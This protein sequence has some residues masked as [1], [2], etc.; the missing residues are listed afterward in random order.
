MTMKTIS[1]GDRGPAV[2]DIQRRLLFLG[3][4][5]GS[6]GVDGD[7]QI[8]TQE[9]IAHFQE[10]SDLPVTGI[11]DDRTWSTLVDSSFAFGDRLL[12]LRAPYFH[13]N[14]VAQLQEILNTLGFYCGSVDAIF[15]AFTER[16][17]SEFQANSALEPDSVVGAA[18]FDALMALHHIW[19]GKSVPTHSAAAGRPRRRN[20][21]LADTAL[22]L[23]A[24]DGNAYRIA[25]RVANLAQAAHGQAQVTVLRDD[26]PADEYSEPGAPAASATKLCAGLPSDSGELPQVQAQ[27]YGARLTQ[28]GEEAS[29]VPLL[30]VRLSSTAK[31]VIVTGDR[32]LVIPLPRDIG[33][34]DSQQGYQH[35]AAV[36]LDVICQQ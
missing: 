13:G 27:Q 32:D 14:D 26:S 24:T 6:S 2:E 12:Y 4:S 18:T 34:R 20:A 29:L 21:F 5:L 28:Q 1:I 19:G 23:V 16:A 9:A 7:F 17:V 35:I 36:I 25:R 3:Y 10:V 30:R 15:G 33:M 11:V 22:E 31:D 8:D